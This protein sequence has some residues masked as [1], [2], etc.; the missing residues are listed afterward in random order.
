[1]FETG[2]RT[3]VCGNTAAML[4]ERGASWLAEHFEVSPV[5]YHR[6]WAA[7]PAKFRASSS[8]SV[9]CRGNVLPCAIR[10]VLPVPLL[11][12]VLSSAVFALV[13]CMAARAWRC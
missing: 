7:S 11:F 2:R 10:V 1:M 6:L 3:P 5:S 13:D 12:D 8:C 9:S 4:G